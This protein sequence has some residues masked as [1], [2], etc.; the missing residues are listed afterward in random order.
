MSA[1]GKVFVE[2]SEW[3]INESVAAH[4]LRAATSGKLV[5]GA[6]WR[7]DGA[8]YLL[9]TA[10]ARPPGQELPL[11]MRRKGRKMRDMGKRENIKDFSCQPQ[12]SYEALEPINLFQTY[13][14][15]PNI[16][17]LQNLTIDLAGYSSC[18]LVELPSHSTYI[19]S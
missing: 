9:H 3:L 1:A 11:N 6:Q 14:I 12:N 5:A 4:R 8:S 16:F 18:S 13:E 19:G 10:E 7:W 2:V 17:S 15:A